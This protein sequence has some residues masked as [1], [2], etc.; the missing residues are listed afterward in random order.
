V[1]VLVARELREALRVLRDRGI[2]TLLAEGGAG[3]AGG[4]L[5]AGCVDRLLLIEA[6]VT[7]GPGAL[8]AF[9]CVPSRDAVLASFELREERRLGSDVLKILAPREADV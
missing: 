7:L 9:A 4:L 6:P 2:Q 1:E 8:G 3:I 5:S